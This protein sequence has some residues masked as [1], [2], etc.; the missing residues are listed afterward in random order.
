MV[1]CW[2]PK[3]LTGKALR[4]FYQQTNKNFSH[5]PTG[6]KFYPM[7]HTNYTHQAV[8]RYL[9][10]LPCERYLLRAVFDLE[11]GKTKAQKR[12]WTR[13]Q[14][15]KSVGKLKSLNAEGWHIF[16]RPL[17]TEYVLIDDVKPRTLSEVCKINPSLVME[18]SSQNYQVF[19]RL[20]ESPATE[21]ANQLCKTLAA[22]YHG[23]PG[24]ADAMHLGR[25]PGFTNRKPKHQMPS[26]HYPFVKIVV[27]QNCTTSFFP[28][29]GAVCL[30]D[31]AHCEG[32]TPPAAS[33]PD[34]SREDFALACRMH[35]QGKAEAEISIVLS[36][37]EKGSSRP[38]YVEMTVRNARNAV[39]KEQLIQGSFRKR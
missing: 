14:L 7:N 11:D 36:Q 37:Q 17:S 1:K 3:Q 34:R 13:D 32:Y 30:T 12:E 38:K 20:P 18:T 8:S 33:G 16:I 15:L 24:S 26:G 25:L 21:Q 31:S 2:S 10:A 5:A 6:D 39:E 35:R 4:P 23:D 22:Q 29:T 27:A 19:L 28:L 9:D